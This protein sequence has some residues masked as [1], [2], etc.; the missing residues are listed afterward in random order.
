M[1]LPLRI[2][3]PF[4]VQTSWQMPWQMAW[5]ML[6]WP[7][8]PAPAAAQFDPHSALAKWPAGAPRSR[9]DFDVR[10]GADGLPAGDLHERNAALLQPGARELRTEAAERLRGAIP[11]L[12]IVDDPVF[13]TPRWVASTKQFLT[14]V[15]RG[16]DFDAVEVTRDFVAAHRDLFEIAPDEL[17]HARRSRDYRTVHN[18][19][20]HLTFQQ[21]IGGVDLFG[22]ELRANVTRRGELVNVSS[23]MLPR[24]EGDFS[25]APAEWSAAQAIRAA[26]GHIGARLSEDPSPATAIRGPSAFQAWR[27][28]ADFRAGVA[29]TTELVYFPVTREE[30]RSAWKVLLPE[31][32]VGNTYEVIVDATDGSCLWRRNQ[33]Q[34]LVGGTQD[35][36][37]RVYTL[38]SPAPG[39][40][41]NPTPNGF[42]FPFATRQLLTITPASVPESPQ[43]WIN[44]GDNDTQ[45]NNV[46]AHLDL[47]DNDQP[48]LPRPT[49]AP[50]RVFDFAQ[51]NL[52]D[53]TAWREAA[54]TNLFYYC[55]V[56]HDR[57]FALGFDEAAGNF[58]AINFSGQGVATDRLFAD[59]QDGGGTNNANFGVGPDGANP[60]MQMYVFDGPTPDRDG[61]LDADIIY[62]EYSHGLSFRLHNLALGGT[63]AGGMG[64]GWG[65]FFGVCLNAEPADDPDGVYV[66]GGYTTYELAPGYVDNYYFGIRRFPYCTDVNK[67]P[68][69][70]GDADPSQ[71]SYPP[72]VPR[73]PIIGNTA[74]EVHNVGE[75]WCNTLIEV[76]SH[77]WAVNGFAANELTMQLVVDGMKLDPAN[78]DFLEARDAILQADLVNNGGAN[79]VPLWEAFSKRGCG[80]SATSPG[81]STSGIVEGFDLPVEFEYP[82]G[83]PER[84]DPGQTRTFQVNVAGLGAFQP[85][86]GSGQLHVSVNGGASTAVPMVETTPN[87]YDATLPAGACFDL[88][89]FAVSVDTVHGTVWNPAGGPEQAFAAPVQTGTLRFFGD[90]FEADQGWT[91][92]VNGATSGAW[93]RGVP[94]D[95]SSWDFDPRRDGDGSGQCYLTMNQPGNTDVD[96]G[97]VTLIS[98]VLDMTGGIDVRYAYY[99]NLTIESGA[100]QL[101]VE[102]DSNG[103]AGPWTAIASHTTSGGT[104]W[105]SHTIP[106]AVIANLGVPFTSTMQVRFTANDGGTPSIVEAGV[107]G[108]RL[109]RQH[110][111]PILGVSS[112]AGD[113]VAAPCPCA[114]NGAPDQGC[115]NSAG[116]RGARMVASGTTTPDTVML[117]TT[118]EVD[119]ALSIVVQGTTSIA[120]VPYGDGLRCVGGT[121]KRLYVT[122]SS[123]GQ[124][125]VPQPGDLAV[126]ARSA[127]LGDAIPSG[128]S[129]YY[130]TYYQDPEPT[131]CGSAG[132]NASN[133]VSIVW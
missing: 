27:P 6:L 116:T 36:T 4:S 88:Q 61:S 19:V 93:E 80:Y 98:P 133:A 13:G 99:L 37:M 1:K 15:A 59:A 126:S 38:D 30:I 85:I 58:Q 103:G 84:L 22:A 39:S 109:E 81:G 92:T 78:P 127:A 45:G 56:Y 65:D 18:G 124:I 50:F 101:L 7:M 48:D 16:G 57:L 42:Q 54:V 112:C 95:D 106:A 128:A 113:G 28:S 107:D 91:S 25:P 5:P 47:D 119:S 69:T 20:R 62:H 130:L 129:R 12:R 75:I 74:N 26:A 3:R 97:S 63:Q 100:D 111:A 94:V 121:L 114:N 131:F 87:H 41:G 44:D 49:G 14:P 90:D 2:L 79:E 102:I 89:T 108:F 46:D 76:R 115:E 70:Y 72:G 83:V 32:G 66:T 125:T 110:C 71:Q 31:V 104:G 53:P 68:Q 21:Q 122:T 120:P 33:T 105:R 132:F 29:V 23:T 82:N 9:P 118:G 73:S 64:E 77:L 11:F 123:G 8:L 43:G 10:F 24:P 17:L 86:A 117:T 34:F 67:N 40:P 96:G 35:V 52:L 51:D 55:N 60:R